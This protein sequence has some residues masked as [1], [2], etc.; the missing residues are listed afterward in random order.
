MNFAIDV[1]YQYDAENFK[2][3]HEAFESNDIEAIE[4]EWQKA[5][6]IVCS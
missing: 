1:V 6:P 3:L 2:R 4:Q 5:K